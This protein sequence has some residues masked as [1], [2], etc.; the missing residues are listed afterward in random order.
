MSKFKLK[1]KLTGL[2]IEIEGD[3]ESAPQ[4]ADNIGRQLSQM[5]QPAALIEA[6]RE[7]LIIDADYSSNGGRPPRRRRQAAKTAPSSGIGESSATAWN[8]DA[9]KWGTPRQEWKS[10]HKIAWMLYVMEK[11]TGKRPEL[12][13]GRMATAF[14][15]TFRSS[16][17]VHQGSI[18]RDLKREPDMFGEMKGKWFL[19]DKGN[20]LVVEKLL[21]EALGKVASATNA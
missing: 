1:L 21:P 7:P 16:G 20:Q 19:K 2:E 12:G 17:L 6:P 5:I 15:S 9:D 8:H 3:R 10:I 18:A 4:M 11:A 14:N 13:T